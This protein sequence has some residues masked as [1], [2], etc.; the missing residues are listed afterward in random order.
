M[1]TSQQ[2]PPEQ[3][4]MFGWHEAMQAL[5][6]GT[7]RG[8]LAISVQDLARQGWKLSAD[9]L[10][11]MLPRVDPAAIEQVPA[12]A[13]GALNGMRRGGPP[14]RGPFGRG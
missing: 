6:F 4:I 7:E 12:G 14:G 9:G 11:R 13:L 5:V 10:R 2:K 8:P 1:N 3:T